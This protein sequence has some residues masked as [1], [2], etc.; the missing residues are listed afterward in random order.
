M[1]TMTQATYLAESY[2]ES[3]TANL[4]ANRAVDRAAYMTP[5]EL[6]QAAYEAS[7]SKYVTAEVALTLSGLAARAYLELAA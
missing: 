1:R 7:T 6:S 5:G 2:Q 3:G 4:A